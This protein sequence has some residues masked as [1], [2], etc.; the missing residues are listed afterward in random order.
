MNSAGRSFAHSCN[1]FTTIIGSPAAA[2]QPASRIAPIPENPVAAVEDELR[3]STLRQAK[4]AILKLAALLDGTP[5]AASRALHLIGET[6]AVYGEMLTAI[7]VPGVGRKRN[8]GIVG[9]YAASASL[10]D[11]LASMETS[12]GGETY[13]NQAL[14]QFNAGLKQIADLMSGRKDKPS[15]PKGPTAFDIES[16]T[17]AYG[18]AKRESLD[19]E[20]VAKLKL[21]LE[22]ALAA[23]EWGPPSGIDP[24][25][26]SV[27][28]L[29]VAPLLEG[30]ARGVAAQA[31]LPVSDEEAG[32]LGTE[33]EAT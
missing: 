10:N 31:G 19:P 28:P 8:H 29:P 20:I 22:E 12:P 30:V 1:R 25:D 5:A 9:Q 2:P 17:R 23:Q 14:G 18:N 32:A 6:A 15:K 13:G 27:E 4:D 33:E 24:D 21:R 7:G 11:S 16:L 26:L 3:I